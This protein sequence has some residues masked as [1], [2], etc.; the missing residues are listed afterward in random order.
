MR[1][2]TQIERLPSITLT[3]L[4]PAKAPALVDRDFRGDLQSGFRGYLNGH[5]T[6]VEF[7]SRH[8]IS[9]HPFSARG[10]DE[11]L[12]IA[13]QGFTLRVELNH[14]IAGR[15]FRGREG[16]VRIGRAFEAR[17]LLL[18]DRATYCI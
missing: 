5:A 2:L 10:N 7:L 1:A 18:L 13:A 11:Q 8:S 16:R 9:D 17:R 15:Q 14:L 4:I 12:L 3:F 6:T